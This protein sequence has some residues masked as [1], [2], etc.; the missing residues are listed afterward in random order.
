MYSPIC[1]RT[2]GSTAV[3]TAQVLFAQRAKL[4]VFDRSG[5]QWKERGLGDLKLLQNLKTFQIRIVMRREQVSGG[6]V[7]RPPVCCHL[8][9]TAQHCEVRSAWETLLC[10]LS[11]SCN[12]FRPSRVPMKFVLTI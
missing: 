8:N 5:Q 2:N 12:L 1:N 6:G 7:W 9:P 4:Y 11:K 3:F 10:R